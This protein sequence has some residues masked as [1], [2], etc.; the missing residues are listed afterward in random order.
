MIERSCSHMASARQSRYNGFECELTIWLG[1]SLILHFSISISRCLDCLIFGFRSTLTRENWKSFVLKQSGSDRTFGFPVEFL[2]VLFGLQKEE[3]DLATFKKDYQWYINHHQKQNLLRRPGNLLQKELEKP[4]YHRWRY[5][6]ADWEQSSCRGDS[7]NCCAAWHRR[8]RRNFRFQ[9]GRLL[10]CRLMNLLQRY[11]KGIKNCAAIHSHCL[12]GPGQLRNCSL[13]RWKRRAKP[14][15]PDQVPMP[16]HVSINRCHSRL[17]IYFRWMPQI[18][19]FFHS[20][21]IWII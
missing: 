17:G 16:Y 5:F 18:N 1:Q 7:A 19:Y 6:R 10:H 20:A 3:P 2:R 13:Q 11:P 21:H 14:Y 12:V 9:G 8:D 15:G 4:R